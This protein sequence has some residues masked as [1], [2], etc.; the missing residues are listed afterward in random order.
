MSV[1][2]G[3]IRPPYPTQ[4]PDFRPKDDYPRNYASISGGWVSNLV[5]VESEIYISRNVLSLYDYPTDDEPLEVWTGPGKTGTQFT[6]RTD[7][8]DILD[9]EFALDYETGKIAFSNA[10]IND[11]VYITYTRIMSVIRSFEQ[12]FNDT[13]VVNIADALLNGFVRGLKF[14]YSFE[15]TSP[16]RIIDVSG[17]TGTPGVEDFLVY[18]G[19]GGGL[20][21]HPLGMRGDG[22]IFNLGLMPCIEGLGQIGSIVDRSNVWD[23]VGAKTIVAA[24]ELITPKIR[25]DGADLL[26][27]GGVDF[28]LGVGDDITIGDGVSSFVI[29]KDAKIV[30]EPNAGQ[31]DD[32]IA[33]KLNGLE[34]T[35]NGQ[36]TTEDGDTS[37]STRIALSQMSGNFDPGFSRDQSN[38]LDAVGYAFADGTPIIFG[39]STIKPYQIV[40]EYETTVAADYISRVRLFQRSTTPAPTILYDSGAITWGSGTTG[41]ESNFVTV[42]P[43][44]SPNAIARLYGVELQCVNST[45]NS[46]YVY[47]INLDCRLA[48]A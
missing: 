11:T 30:I 24:T 42:S 40:V 29:D 25:G 47:A 1:P 3:V 7:G 20:F 33:L 13:N 43:A 44:I 36:I 32:S 10:N 22:I 41:Y 37:V 16:T 12:T 45:A 28:D 38:A 9:G 26:V 15:G 19:D 18:G 48:Y 21:D 2:I 5:D 17:M 35:K 6:E 23:G 14:V 46:I 4:V 8:G 39:G 27:D 34:I 31:S